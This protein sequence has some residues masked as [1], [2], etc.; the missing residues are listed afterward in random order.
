MGEGGYRTMLPR[1][2][3]RP[4]WTINGIWRVQYG[5]QRKPRHVMK[6]CAEGNHPNEGCGGPPLPRASPPNVVLSAEVDLWGTIVA[7]VGENEHCGG[8]NGE[9]NKGISLPTE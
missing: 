6:T 4:F 1:T 2:D 8:W 9:N 7:R 3:S 5:V